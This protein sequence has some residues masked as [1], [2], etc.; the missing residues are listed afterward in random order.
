MNLLPNGYTLVIPGTG[1]RSHCHYVRGFSPDS[2]R[3]GS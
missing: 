1:I 3:T 2:S